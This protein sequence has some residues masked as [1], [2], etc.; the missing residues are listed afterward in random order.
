MADSSVS[1][2]TN[3]SEKSKSSDLFV[4]SEKQVGGSYVSKKI[5]F[6]NLMRSS[7]DFFGGDLT[8]WV[9]AK[10]R[11]STNPARLAF[12]GDSNVAGQ[13]AGTGGFGLVNALANSFP[14]KIANSFGFQKDSFFG[15]QNS[16]SVSLNSFDPR[17][18]LGSGWAV[19][20]GLSAIFGGRFIIGQSAASGKLAFTPTTSF[21]KFRYWYPT[22][23]GLNSAVGVYVD[24]ALIDT[25]N[26]NAASGFTYKDY[27]VSSGTHTIEF[28]VG[29]GTGNGFVAGVEIF[30][31]TD[32]PVLLQGGIC[33]G[34]SA[35]F[36]SSSN[37]WHYKSSLVNL[38][39]D[40]TLIY[41]TIN[42]AD[43]SVSNSTYFTN[44]ENLVK[45]VPNSNGCLCVGFP[46]NTAKNLDGTIDDYARI[47]KNI[48]RD[49]GWFFIDCRSFLGRS[50][51]KANASGYVFDAYHPNASGHDAIAT[52]IYNVLKEAGM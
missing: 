40:F 46:F 41:C 20:S 29:G 33:S 12:I 48:A 32:K 27:T 5:S 19:D 42:D 6:L 2:L 13:G 36:N 22:L 15:D 34:K 37:P 44:I 23:S 43:S 28:G 21:T 39:P 11:G 7:E 49:Y 8:K 51:S 26:Q 35:D 4:I 3:E 10:A 24:G 17:I 16:V 18:T 50:Y 14:K 45:A 31:G 25:I 30:D 47:L 9:A 1:N 38:A 52:N